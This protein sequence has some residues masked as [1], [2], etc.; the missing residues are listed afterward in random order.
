MNATTVTATTFC[1]ARTAAHRTPPNGALR[2]D[3][4][5]PPV[6]TL[7]VPTVSRTKPQ[8]IPRC[9]IA[10]RGSLNIFVW[11]K[12]YWIRPETR[13]RTFSNGLGTGG[14]RRREHAQVAGHR[15]REDHR[16]AP[17]HDEH[18]RVERDVGVDLD[19]RAISGSGRSG[20]AAWPAPAA[21]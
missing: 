21:P 2:I 14:A 4:M 16:G 5:R 18:Q 7:A 8:K 9:R 19:H 10:A 13:A 1:I 15:Q 6:T 12:A 3:W 20:R 17:E 11:T